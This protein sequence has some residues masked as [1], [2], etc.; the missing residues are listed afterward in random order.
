MIIILLELIGLYFLRRLVAR[1]IIST[2]LLVFR[3]ISIG[4]WIYALFTLPGVLLHEIAHFLI[5]ALL[6]LRTGS[7]ELLPTLHTDGSLELGS[8]QVQAT[9]FLRQLL[10]GIAPLLFSFPM[11]VWLSSFVSF[12]LNLSS[13]VILYL[14][15]TF[16][17]H[18]FPS[19]RDLVSLPV[20][21]ALLLVGILA[22]WLLGWHWTIDWSS[23]FTFT[24]WTARISYSLLI[25]IV[26]SIG[27]ILITQ[28]SAFVFRLRSDVQ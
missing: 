21:M 22:V 10:V 4:V 28:L 13:L 12:D 15:F 14:L 11:I 26:M 24:V 16:A 23:L 19:K 27:I 25:A 3:K 18:M 6:G 2:S 20:V 17:L 8:V 5:A 1:S 9:D 7:I